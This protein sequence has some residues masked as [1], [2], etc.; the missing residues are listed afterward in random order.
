MTGPSTATHDGHVDVEG[1]LNFR[2]AGGWVNEAGRTMRTGVLYR[3]DDPIRITAAGREAVAAL[4]LAASIDVRQHSQYKRS[5]GFID[6][7][8]TYHR[9]LVDRVINLD[10]PP[11]LHEPSDMGD[12]Y[13]D[14]IERSR[15]QIADVLDIVA[16]H[17]ASGPVLVHCAYGKDRTG[18]IIALIQ[19]ALGMSAETLVA[20]YGRSDG[21]TRR[22]FQFVKDNPLPD[23]PEWWKAPPSLFTAPEAAM[24]SL[25]SRSVDRYGSL[26]EWVASFP[27]GEHTLER[28]RAGLLV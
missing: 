7:A 6:P 23:D 27:L 1:C 9:P 15:P 4:H 3:A 20:D 16:D 28:L 26:H 5:P 8:H 12:L 21:P 18:I 19:A 22:R 13:E 14:M 2:D 17:V 11:Q 10:D 25:A 24:A